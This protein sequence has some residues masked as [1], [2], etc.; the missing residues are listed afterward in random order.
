MDL[1]MAKSNETSRFILESVA[2]REKMKFV[3][4]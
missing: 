2:A 4:F 3:F 1:S